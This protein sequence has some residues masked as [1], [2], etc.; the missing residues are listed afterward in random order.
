M[1]RAK[2]LILERGGLVAKKASGGVNLFYSEA[3][4]SNAFWWQKMFGEAIAQE[5]DE[6]PISGSGTAQVTDSGQNGNPA[7]SSNLSW[8]TK[9]PSRW[10]TTTSTADSTQGESAPAPSKAQAASY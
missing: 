7:E 5:E 1:D 3:P 10:N 8:I 2:T 6:A 9:F 4:K